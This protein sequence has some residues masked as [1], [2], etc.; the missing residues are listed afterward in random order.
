MTTITFDTQELVNELETSGFTRKQ[1][2]TVVAVLKKSQSE[3]ATKDD[4]HREIES[5]KNVT[6]TDLLEL[7]VDLVKWV[8]ALMLA[9][10]AVIAALVKLL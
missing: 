7:K 9:Q 10:V 1:P 8:G 6:K 2:E 3:L 4:L 5:L